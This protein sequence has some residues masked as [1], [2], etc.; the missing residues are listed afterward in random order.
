MNYYITK[1]YD[2]SKLKEFKN[3]EKISL[4]DAMV[5]VYARAI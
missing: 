1:D 4:N 2:L 5:Y 3:K